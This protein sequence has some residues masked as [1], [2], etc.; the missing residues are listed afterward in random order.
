MPKMNETNSELLTKAPTVSVVLPTYNEAGEILT[1]FAE[2]ERQTF[3]DFEVLVIDDG[4][5]DDTVRLAKEYAMARKNYHVILTEHRGPAHAYNV[6]IREAKGDII[7]IG[8]GDC[9]YDEDF[10]EQAVHAFEVD[11][12]A[13][14]VCL[15]GGPL[16]VR[17][18]LA[19]EC[20]LI[21]NAVQHQLL[22]KGKIK[23]F[24]AWVFRK[25]AIMGVGGYDESLHQG[26][27]KDL[28]RRFT[29]AGNK[30]AW[31]PGIH[32]KHKRDLTL[33]QLLYKSYRR[34]R[35]RSLVSLKHRLALE[36][37]RKLGPL[38]G[39]VA[40]PIIGAFSSFASVAL[41]FLVL[42]ATIARSISVVVT[43]WPLVE[44][45]RFYFG[46]PFFLLSR[47]L[48]TGLGYSVGIAMVLIRK[49]RGQEISWQNV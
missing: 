26:E 23:P 47:N 34:G 27:D 19:T 4:S 16:L 1:T 44:R 15:T 28:F 31:V 3:H 41:L 37:I 20:I 12:G 21:E 49:L 25:D 2:F 7:F 40:V 8:E 33:A 45:K 46:Y 13:N 22:R 48:A 17:S 5:T 10:L 42:L 11:P 32:W 38:W 6:G 29:H 30:V 18:T 14:A 39:L 35:S 9:V 43:S 24:Y 36:L